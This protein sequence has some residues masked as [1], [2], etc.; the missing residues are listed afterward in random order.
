MPLSLINDETFYDLLM[1][2]QELTRDTGT[3]LTAEDD[4]I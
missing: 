1:E 2:Q 4:R 3:E